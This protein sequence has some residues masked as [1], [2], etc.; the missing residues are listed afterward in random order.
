MIEVYRCHQ[1]VLQEDSTG[2]AAKEVVIYR[3]VKLHIIHELVVWATVPMHQLIVAC[4]LVY[5]SLN[6]CL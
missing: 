2:T 6:I 4:C 3:S 5:S 1:S